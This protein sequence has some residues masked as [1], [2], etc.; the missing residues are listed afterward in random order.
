MALRWTIRWL[1]VSATQRVPSAA[2]A[3]PSGS[4]SAT[5]DW[6]RNVPSRPNFSMRLLA[7]SATNTLLAEMATPFGEDSWPGPEPSEPKAE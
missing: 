3:T 2:A 5:D 6:A 4:A 1:P 7:V